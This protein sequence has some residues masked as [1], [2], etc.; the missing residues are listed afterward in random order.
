MFEF[1]GAQKFRGEIQLWLLIW[2]GQNPSVSQVRL[3]LSI[4]CFPG[5]CL[6]DQVSAGFSA[7]LF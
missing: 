4:T 2:G 1:V 7:N 6:S 5:A 3:T